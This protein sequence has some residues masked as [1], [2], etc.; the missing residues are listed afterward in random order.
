MEL[1]KPLL[2]RRLKNKIILTPKVK[3]YKNVGKITLFYKNVGF[4]AVFYP[5]MSIII[6]N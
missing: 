4:S 6:E 5:K 1:T 2:K 3:S